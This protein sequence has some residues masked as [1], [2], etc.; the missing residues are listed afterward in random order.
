MPDDGAFIGYTLVMASVDP[1]LSDQ[2]L[3]ELVR[4]MPLHAVTEMHGEHGLRLRLALECENLPTSAQSIVDDALALAS[5][6]HAHDRRTREPYM[7]HLLRSAVRVLTYYHVRDPDVVVAT[8][9][10]DAV[11]DHA[12]ELAGRPAGQP[13]QQDIDDA[14]AVLAARFT[15]RVAELVEA[16]T[17]PLPKP[18]VDRHEQYRAHVAVSLT[19][20]PWARVIKAS[21]FT[22]N[23]V[24]LIY[25]LTHR[26]P[27]LARK[28]R[29]LIPVLRELIARP[30]TPLADDVKAHILRQLDLARERM[31]AILS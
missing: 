26:Q 10:H 13:T 30:D 21:D 8:L 22:D 2:S 11:E 28:Y 20:H 12:P 25:T 6:L 23:G 31:D 29:P 27:K 15:P 7:N 19:A 5:R 1:T 9:L 17:N 14:L 4:T 16:V 18:G 24:G 3:R